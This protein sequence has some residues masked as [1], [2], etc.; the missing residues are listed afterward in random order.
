MGAELLY[1]LSNKKSAAA[2]HLYEKL[3]FVHDAEIMQTYGARYARCDVA[4]R[5]VG[6]SATTGA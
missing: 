2:I 5:Y 1:L 3:G 6:G 4:M